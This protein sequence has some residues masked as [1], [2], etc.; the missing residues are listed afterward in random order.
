[1][2]CFTSKNI[3]GSKFRT[4]YCCLVVIYC[5]KEFGKVISKS[6]PRF[7]TFLK[8][9]YKKIKINLPYFV[10]IFKKIDKKLTQL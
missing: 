5:F 1:M 9:F 3:N 8:I 10:P 4:F 2:K 6:G 7:N